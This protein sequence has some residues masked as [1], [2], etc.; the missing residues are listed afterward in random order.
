MMTMARVNELFRDYFA[1]KA[2]GASISECTEKLLLAGEATLALRASEA[3]GAAQDEAFTLYYDVLKEYR[4]P[5]TAPTRRIVNNGI[6]KRRAL[7]FSL[8]DV[9]LHGARWSIG[10]QLGYEP[11]DVAVLVSQWRSEKA[12][13]ALKAQESVA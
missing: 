7:M 11:H 10:A 13:K 5:I 1:A 2:A 6:L 9:G 8:L 4:W 12:A 3:R